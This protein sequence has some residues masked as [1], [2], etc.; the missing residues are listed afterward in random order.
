MP[1]GRKKIFLTKLTDFASS[2]KEG[3]GTVRREGDAEYIWLKGVASTAANSVV[4]FDESYATALLQSGTDPVLGQRIA[5]AKA[6]TVAS[7]YGWY[8]IRG[9]A[10]SVA[11]G[12]TCAADSQLYNSKSTAGRISSSDSG[13]DQIEGMWATTAAS[14]NVAVCTLMYPYMNG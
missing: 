6:A 2:D 10:V 8:Q 1:S 13:N 3:V 5:V 4:A 11:C 7:K 9:Q 12:G 14:S